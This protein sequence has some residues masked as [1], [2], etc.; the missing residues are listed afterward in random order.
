MSVVAVPLVYE[1]SYG[2]PYVIV[3]GDGLALHGPLFRDRN[4]DLSWLTHDADGGVW[5][6]SNGLPGR[7]V[8]RESSPL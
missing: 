6:N 5:G 2:V 7:A 8:H 4:E 3:R 1:L